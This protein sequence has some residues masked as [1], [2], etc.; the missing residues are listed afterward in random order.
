M[1]GQ[2]QG[3]IASGRQTAPPLSEVVSV[4]FRVCFQWLEAFLLGS[5]VLRLAPA[6]P[7]RLD[8]ARRSRAEV[9][10][11]LVYPRLRT[12]LATSASAPRYPSSLKEGRG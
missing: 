5:E 12:N 1:A 8:D 6:L 9:Y 4:T 2:V 10:P 7:H 11:H 3:M